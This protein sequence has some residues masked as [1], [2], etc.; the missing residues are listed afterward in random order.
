MANFECSQTGGYSRVE[1]YERYD[2]RAAPSAASYVIVQLVSFVNVPSIS[3]TVTQATSG[4]TGT[5]IAINNVTGATYLAVTQVTGTFDA[6]HDLT[7]SGPVTIGTATS[8]DMAI[9]AKTDATY[10]AAAADVYRALIDAVPGSGPILGVVGMI[11]SGVDHVYAFR[12]NTGATAVAIY[13]ASSSGWTLVPFYDLVKWTAGTGSTTPPADGETLT[14][15]AVTATIKR[16]M[17][18][19]GA[20]AVSGGTAVGAFVITTPSGGNFAAGSA[21]TTSGITVTLSGVQTAITLAT[22]GRF[23]FTKTNFSGQIATRRI[24]GCDGVNQSFELDGDV[25]APIATGLSPDSPTYI[26][27]HYELSHS[28]QGRIADLLRCRDAV[29]M[30]RGG[31]RRRDRDGQYRHRLHHGAREPDNADAGRVHGQQLRLSLWLVGGNVRLRAIQ[32]RLGRSPR[33]RAKPVRHIFL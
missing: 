19:S 10:T 16:V 7:V 29:Q 6:T 24:Y 32:Y 4:A 26:T 1:G 18:Q 15:G 33:Q 13:K 14:Q 2:G 28:R 5:V 9:P 27:S 11:F 20:F 30:G 25:L 22:G 8:R 21:T 31:R 17:W 3:A 23:R 12:A